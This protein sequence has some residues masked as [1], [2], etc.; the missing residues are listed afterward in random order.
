[1]KIG[2]RST[3]FSAVYQV[4]AIFAAQLVATK[5]EAVNPEHLDRLAWKLLTSRYQLVDRGVFV[6][7][8]D[9][10]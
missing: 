10:S 4:I 7:I 9:T 1:L 5:C 6:P 8:R 3:Q 2:S